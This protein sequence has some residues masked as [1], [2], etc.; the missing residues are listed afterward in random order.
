VDDDTAA[1]SRALDAAEQ[2]FYGR[3]VQAVGMDAVRAASGLSL[4]RLYA[5]YPSK[6]DLVEA[7]LLRRDTRW[8]GDLAAHV[9]AAT[10]D[11]GGRL[12]AVFDWL[13]AWFDE[14]GYR[15]CAFLN[16][17][18]ELGAGSPAV[19]A[20]ARRHKAEFR[21]WLGTL[22]A[23]A[24]LPA[25]LADHLLLLAEGAIATAALTGGSA[26]ARQARAAAAVLLAAAGPEERA[27]S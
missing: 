6:G 14:P 2:L 13:A 7:Y 1:R 15:G 12:L 21:R 5:L 22:T 27:H 9:A 16:A 11:P 24:G 3:G 4:K 19:A 23:A 18:G 10:T 17:Y 20:A 26:P 8:R 25:A